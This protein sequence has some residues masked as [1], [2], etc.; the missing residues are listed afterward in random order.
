M[1]LYLR[2][3]CNAF[4][5]V[6]SRR[7]HHEARVFPRNPAPLPALVT[8][9][10]AHPGEVILRDY[11][12][13][14][15]ISCRELSRALGVANSRFARVLKGDFDLDAELALRLSKVLGKSA[16]SWL[17]MQGDYDLWRAEAEVDV[18]DLGRIGEGAGYWLSRNRPPIPT[19]PAPGAA[20][21]RR[22]R[23]HR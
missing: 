1:E 23:R 9:R 8:R 4:L 10:P 3:G 20:R 16:R 12:L 22:N 17:T 19:S 18:S 11:L 2:I 21:R 14:R 7:L 5:T 13:P 6:G 15:G